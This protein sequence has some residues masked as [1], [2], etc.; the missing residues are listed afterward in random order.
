MTDPAAEIEAVVLDLAR[1]AIKRAAE[2]RGGLVDR[3]LQVAD[4]LD[5]AADAKAA[6]IM[7]GQTTAGASVV[8]DL[9]AFARELRDAV[10][11]SR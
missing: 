8:Y 11:A 7:T 3:V 5:R 1:A 4:R 9:R 10:G 2:S 6:A